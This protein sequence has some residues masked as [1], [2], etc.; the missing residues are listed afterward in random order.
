MTFQKETMLQL[1]TYVY[2][3][4][5]P[6]QLYTVLINLNFIQREHCYVNTLESYYLISSKVLYSPYII[7]YEQPRKFKIF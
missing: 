1:I 3:S 5:N 7:K 6:P 4:L 2:Q